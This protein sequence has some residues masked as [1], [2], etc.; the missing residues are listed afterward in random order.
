MAPG[1][2]TIGLD[3]FTIRP[4]PRSIIG[5]HQRHSSYTPQC[6][7]RLFKL[8]DR[9]GYRRHTGAP[10]G[11]LEGNGTSDTPAGPGDQGYPP[12]ERCGHREAAASRAARISL[13]SERVV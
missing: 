13:G 11:Q 7:S 9:A 8:I 1:W 12:V 10:L 2:S 3:T 5:G 6:P 4:Q